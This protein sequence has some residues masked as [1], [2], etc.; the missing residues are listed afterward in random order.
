MR[1]KDREEKDPDTETSRRFQASRLLKDRMRRFAPVRTI[2]VRKASRC[3][4][5]LAASYGLT[6]AQHRILFFSSRREVRNL[7]EVSVSWI[8]SFRL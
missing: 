4:G 1:E 5:V 3:A 8:F 7:R 6:G 2:K